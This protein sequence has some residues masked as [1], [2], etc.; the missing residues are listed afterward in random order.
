MAGVTRVVFAYVVAVVALAGVV[1]AVLLLGR[2]RPPDGRVAA[3]VEDSG[4]S[5]RDLANLGLTARLPSSYRRACE[6]MAE[7][8]PVRGATCPP[9][10]PV[11]PLEVE[12]ARSFSRAR[13]YA[14]GYSMS[15]AS[16]SLRSYRGLP[17]ETN[18]CHWAYELGWSPRTRRIVVDRVLNGSGNPADP[19]SRC[20]WR[21]VAGQP[22]RACR[23][24]PFDQGGGLHGGHVAYLWERPQATVVLS[25]H[26]YRNE[27]RVKAMMTALIA[28]TSERDH[29]QERHRGLSPSGD[30]KGVFLDE[31]PYSRV[32]TGNGE[33]RFAGHSLACEAFLRS[34]RRRTA[35]AGLIIGRSAALMTGCFVIAWR[36]LRST[37]RSRRSQRRIA[38]VPRCC[39]RTTTRPCT[40]ASTLLPAPRSELG[41]RTGPYDSA[42]SCLR[43]LAPCA[44]P[45]SGGSPRRSAEF[46]WR[47]ANRATCRA[48]SFRGS[49][50]SRR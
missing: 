9:V 15:F 45:S 44:T 2:E 6:R 20:E 32:P 13:R 49:R 28:A 36:T 10:V 26:G 30:A 22:V 5:A 33:Q 48:D 42:R 50:V 16:C 23:V 8:A 3:A 37:R 14:A 12:V 21:R 34:G 1:A 25:A 29:T 39:S 7:H 46:P 47:E 19:R 31:S 35:R 38:G 43:D 27:A 18:G 40:W 4:I 41:R 24:P 17:I 11:G